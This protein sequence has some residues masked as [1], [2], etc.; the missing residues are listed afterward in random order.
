M[1]IAY[2]DGAEHH[3]LELLQEAADLSSSSLTAHEQYSSWPIR[4]HLCP[5]RSNLLRH[6]DFAGMDVLE[7]GAG[8]GGASRFI[9]ENARRFVAVEG[10]ESRS[11]AL[12][13]R[14]RDL[15]NW[16]VHVANLQDYQTD[17]RFDVVCLIGVLEYAEL[18]IRPPEGV[19]PFEWT[20]RY[21]SSFLKPGG[22]L[23]VAIEN[24][25]GIKYWAGAPEDHT[26]RMFDGICGYG[27]AKSPRTFSRKGLLEHFRN[28]GLAEVSEYYP[29]PDYK[30]PSSVIDRRLIE[31][32][33]FLAADIAA[34]ATAHERLVMTTYFPWTLAL[35][36]VARSGL[37]AEM[38]NSFLFVA[39][40]AG[41][42]TIRNAF[43]GGPERA[44]ECAWHYSIFRKE[45][46]RT[47][48]H[49]A[50]DPTAK[51]TV[52]KRPVGGV[53][54]RT[55]ATAFHKVDW[56]P[57]QGQEA[58]LHQTVLMI[59]RRSAFADDREGFDAEI[60]RFIRWA[61]QDY[62]FDVD[63]LTEP[64]L[65]LTP[66]N[67]VLAED[68]YQAFDLEWRLKKPLKKSWFILRNIF[69][70]RDA[71]GLFPSPP[72]ATLGALYD[73]LC[74]SCG[75]TADLSGDIEREAEVQ[76]DIQRNTSFESARDSLRSVFSD[77]WRPAPFPKDPIAELRLRGAE[78]RDR[79]LWKRIFTLVKS[80]RAFAGALG[81]RA[82]RLA[83]RAFGRAGSHV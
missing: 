83:Q 34:D 70:V 55:L 65:D 30:T 26:G 64:A 12:R 18:Y 46:I 8:M 19:S 71:L 68:G 73:R 60:L 36:E 59:L 74:A 58:L 78:P 20:I 75:I 10:S 24:R 17:E 51:P 2:C 45:P 52:A 67:A 54:L 41:P 66:S 23:I 11:A 27:H 53:L 76:A 15:D 22:C 62:E 7:L 1:A 56:A 48:F 44:D 40:A 81:R 61:F 25:N 16:E 28:A 57:S 72:D 49:L 31:R 35:R 9:A 13:S 6:L 47:S 14:L 33:P 50:N 43:L 77:P 5:E 69:V 42:S 39:G 82:G 32:F 4:Y 80:P 38:A 21:A 37:L 3:I 29:W 79:A 63:H